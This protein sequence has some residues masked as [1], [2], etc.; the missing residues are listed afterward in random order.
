MIYDRFP[1]YG[2]WLALEYSTKTNSIT[3]SMISLAWNRVSQRNTREPNHT[4]VHGWL[5]FQGFCLHPITLTRWAGSL[6]GVVGR[7]KQ[8]FF[9]V[10]CHCSGSPAQLPRPKSQFTWLARFVSLYRVVIPLFSLANDKTLYKVRF[11]NIG[12]KTMLL[13][14]FLGCDRLIYQISVWKSFTSQNIIV[15][16]EWLYVGIIKACKN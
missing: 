12:F 14:F 1:F 15:M 8:Y 2:V 3:H 7:A 6:G 4:E 10:T 11:L 16:I 5:G 13:S 9:S